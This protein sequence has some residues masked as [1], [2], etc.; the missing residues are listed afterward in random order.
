M[1]GQDTRCLNRAFW[2]GGTNVRTHYDKILLEPF[3]E[4]MLSR[5]SSTR[6]RN[7][8]KCQM[9][10]KVSPNSVQFPGIVGNNSDHPIEVYEHEK[11]K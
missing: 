8:M 10:P 2:V 7:L 1:L 9:S 11:D 6:I 5:I 3:G 4:Y